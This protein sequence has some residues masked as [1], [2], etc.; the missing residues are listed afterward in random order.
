MTIDKPY[1]TGQWSEA[2]FK[3][4]IKGALRAATKRWGPIHRTRKNARSERGVYLCVGYKKKAHKV[5]HKDGICV[6]HISPI[7]GPEGFK[8][9]DDVISRM[10]VEEEFLQVLCKACHDRKTKDER[11][12]HAIAKERSKQDSGRADGG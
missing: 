11:K 5:R 8:T 2:R 1:N 10:F 12:A 6:D 4:F 3:S 9:W 7:I